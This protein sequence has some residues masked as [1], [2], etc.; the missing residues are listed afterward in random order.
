MFELVQPRA[1]PVFWQDEAFS[2]C[3]FPNSID[4]FACVGK[5]KNAEGVRAKPVQETINPFGSIHDGTQLLYQI[6]PSSEQFCA[7]LFRK[8]RCI[9]HA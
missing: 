5:V 6:N 9:E 7:G 4:V 2:L 3:Q 8:A 1:E